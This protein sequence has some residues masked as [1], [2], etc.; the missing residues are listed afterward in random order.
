LESKVAIGILIMAYD[1]VTD[2]PPF[3]E[4][5]LEVYLKNRMS[6]T[7]PTRRELEM[8]VCTAEV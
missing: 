4:V 3:R 8:R 5:R 2:M 7:E 1:D 6:M